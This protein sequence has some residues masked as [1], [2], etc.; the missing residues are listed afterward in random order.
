MVQ[1]LTIK[2]ISRIVLRITIA[3]IGGASTGYFLSQLLPE[4][5]ITVFEKGRIGGRLATEEVDGRKYETG[6]SI[7]HG[8][9]RYMVQFLDICD[10]KKK[11]TP[12]ETPFTL[13]RGDKIVFQ[14]GV[15]F[16]HHHAYLSV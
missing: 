11:N 7:I 1:V 3:G 9:N 14:V 15:W 2:K 10:L 6:G 5:D 16:L 4:V 8:A 12:E 13:H